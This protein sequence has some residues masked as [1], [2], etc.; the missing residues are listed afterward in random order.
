MLVATDLT[1]RSDR[2]VLRAMSLARMLNEPLTLLYVIDEHLPK[3]LREHTQ[4]WAETNLS[5]L[6][7]E[8]GAGV[9]TEVLI[10][11]DKPVKAITKLGMQ[12]DYIV[13]GIHN[14][15]IEQRFSATTAGKILHQSINAVL[16]VREEPSEP[17]KRAVVG[18][19]LSLYSLPAIAQ[20]HNIAPEAELHLLHAYHTPFSGMRHGH[21]HHH[22]HAEEI[23]KQFTGFIARELDQSNQRAREHSLTKSAFKTHLIEGEA[24]EA[25]RHCQLETH[26]DLV[27]IASHSKPTLSRLMF[28]S[29]AENLLQ[30]PPCDVL[31]VRPF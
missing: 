11:V 27:V 9:K 2:A 6:C 18:V 3:G 30:H 25:L 24:C 17:Y 19:D 21:A 12:H 23:T 4:S 28:G 15:Q 26:A 1:A 20:A 7:Q 8:V 16:L 31:V 14:Q 13:L 5:K 22:A 29:V 10:E